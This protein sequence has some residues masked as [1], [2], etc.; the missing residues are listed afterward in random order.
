MNYEEMLAAAEDKQSYHLLDELPNE[1]NGKDTLATGRI[2]DNY[3]YVLVH[4]GQLNSLNNGEPISAEYFFDQATYDQYVDPKT[5]NFDS[6]KLSEALQVKPYQ[7]YD[8]MNGD[9]HA[10]YRNSIACFKVNGTANVLMGYCEAN[11]QFGG[12]GAHEAFI[13]DK[14][15]IQYQES[16]ILVYGLKAYLTRMRRLPNLQLPGGVRQGIVLSPRMFRQNT[17]IW[18]GVLKIHCTESWKRTISQAFLRVR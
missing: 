17:L 1:Y 11:T 10:E 7:S 2:K 13:P 3:I 4:D 16:G 5:G 12:G 9:G 8:M 6:K 14:E 18:Q 15:S